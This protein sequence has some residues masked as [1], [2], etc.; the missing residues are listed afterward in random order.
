[1]HMALAVLLL[2]SMAAG[3]WLLLHIAATA[4]FDATPRCA[5]CGYDLSASAGSDACPEC[6]R[7]AHPDGTHITRVWRYNT[8]ALAVIAAVPT[9]L[10]I[11]LLGLG[12]V[13]DD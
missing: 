7:S 6:G 8:W 13:F 1:M 4:R 10:I 9:L 3:S 2:G 5:G 12:A 11:A